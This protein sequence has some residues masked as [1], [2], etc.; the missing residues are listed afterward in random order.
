MRVGPALG[1]R[2]RVFGCVLGGAV[3][4]ALGA[5]YEG[6]WGAT[7]PA[8]PA[9]LAGF[10]DYDGY[11]RGQWTDDTQLTLATLEAIVEEGHVDPSLIAHAIASLWLNVSVIGPGGACTRAAHAF[12]RS[13]DWS[14]SG[15]PVGKAGNGTAMRTAV[16][17]L[18]FVRRPSGLEQEVAQVS[19]ITH[20]D[21]RSV[22][23]GVAVAK[24]AQLLA[25]DAELS[26]DAFCTQVAAT[27]APLA[28]EFAREVAELPAR[29]R[30]PARVALERIAWAGSALPEFERPI[31]TPFVVPTVL[32]ALWSVLRWPDSWEEAVAGVIGL[33]GDVDTTGAIVGGLMG[34]RLGVSAI[35]A[36]L[37]EGVQQVARLRS[38]AGR[39]ADLIPR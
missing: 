25:L 35:P 27:M 17:G 29:L 38:L 36:H 13:G 19:R 7:I 10:G 21:P 30:E 3:G 24:A 12:L 33:G 8:G 39:Y 18:W 20:Q 31:I 1:P 23:G 5:P 22:A 14:T 16:L 6:L 26:A 28:P 34:T 4:D 32:A 9:L 11:P 37:R 2:E 15:A